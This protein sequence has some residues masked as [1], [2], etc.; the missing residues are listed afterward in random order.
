MSPRTT[1]KASSREFT[2]QNQCHAVSFYFYRINKCETIT[3]EL[4]AIDRRVIDPVAPTPVLANPVRAVGQIATVPQ[5]V[6]AT[7]T[8]RLDVEARG[9]ASQAQYAAA[10]QSRFGVPFAVRLPDGRY[11]LAA[12]VRTA[13]LAE[14]DSALVERACSTRAPDWSRRRRRRRSSF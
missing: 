3:F 2:N 9:L 12:D 13:A 7:A 11:T 4:V 6:P 10:G 1:S 14:V 5:E 8:A